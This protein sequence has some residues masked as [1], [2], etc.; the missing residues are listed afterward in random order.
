MLSVQPCS[1]GRACICH[2]PQ[3]DANGEGPWSGPMVSDLDF[4]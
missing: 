1:L 3:A 2:S 4:E